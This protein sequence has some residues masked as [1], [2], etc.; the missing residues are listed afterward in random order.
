MTPQELEAEILKVKQEIL[1][2]GLKKEQYLKETKLERFLPNPKQLEFLQ[3]STVKRRAGFCGNRFGKSTI[4]VV[5]DCCWLLG[6]RPFFPKG[7]PLRRAGI[8]LRGVKGV[9]IGEDWDK[10]REIF[11]EDKNPD[12]PGKFFDFLPPSKIVDQ[13]RNAIG[14]IDMIVVEND[15]DGRKRRS[16]VFFETVRTFVTSPK[17]VESSDWDFIHCDEPLPK[18]MWTGM[19]RGLIDRGGFSWWLLTPLSE[20]WMYMEMLDQS[21]KAPNLY[22]FFEATMD[23]NPLLSDEDKQLYLDQLTVEERECRRLGKPLAFGRMVLGHFDDK[24]HIWQ[25]PTPPEGWKS[26]AE[27]PAEYMCCYAIDPHPQTP[28]A[29]L[30]IAVSPFGDVFLYDEIFEKCLLSD[31]AQKI[32]ERE[33]N[34]R[35]SLALCDPIAWVR[36]PDTGR[37]WADTFYELG[38]PVVQASKEKSAGIITLNN[39]LGSPRNLK[40]A[41]HLLNFRKEVKTWYFGRDNK[42][43]DEDDHMME[44]FRRLVQH[45]GLT[46]RAPY[47]PEK[48]LP[49]RPIRDE[50]AVINYQLAGLNSDINYSIH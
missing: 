27:P 26:W 37:V 39:L 30:F 41:P 32:K 29:V 16:T 9:V 6:E 10:V 46:Y 2:L 8:P 34:H 4:G 50:F 11:T 48:E 22:W 35:F 33:N 47:V 44:N 14:V 49:V 18:A 31:L 20:P 25:K 13:H 1:T 38:L 3:H 23:D 15:I 45:D 36:N 5:E 19:S 12:M 42:P 24:K 21:A 28:H 17:S 40:V 43:V 7:H